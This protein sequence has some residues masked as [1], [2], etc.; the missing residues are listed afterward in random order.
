[1][2]GLWNN[3][4]GFFLSLLSFSLIHTDISV[5]TWIKPAQMH[6]GNLKENS[7]KCYWAFLPKR[8][9]WQISLHSFFQESGDLIAARLASKLRNLSLSERSLSSSSSSWSNTSSSLMTLP[10]LATGTPMLFTDTF[11][12]T[13]SILQPWY[14][15]CPV[16]FTSR[17][18]S[19]SVWAGNVLLYCWSRISHSSQYF[20]HISCDIWWI[21]AGSPFS[22]AITITPSQTCKII[23]FNELRSS[24]CLHHLVISVSNSCSI[25]FKSHFPHLGKTK[26][27][28]TVVW[29]IRANMLKFGKKHYPSLSKTN[30]TKLNNEKLNLNNRTLKSE[31]I[32]MKL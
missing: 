18:V 10:R 3:Q 22:Y 4:N 19:I 21:S 1:M 6:L 5:D 20:S 9:S 12:V 14:I 15:S 30:K 7:I 27:Y 8:I 11:S 32:F 17:S 2:K 25:I 28:S 29:K 31:Y 16:L 13:F 24:K 23:T 26:F